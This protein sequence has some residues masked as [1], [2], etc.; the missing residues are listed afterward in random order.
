MRTIG[1]DV[2]KD[3]LDLALW[4]SAET[5]VEHVRCPN[6]ATDVTAAMAWVRARTPDLVVLEATG[7]YHAPMVAALTA[8]DVPLALVNP[9]QLKAERIVQQ[10]RH[11]TDRAD[12]ALLARFAADHA[13]DL[14][15]YVA[16]PAAQA[17]LRAI[18]SYRDGLVARQTELRNQRAAAD[19]HGTTL[20]VAWLDADLVTLAAQLRTVDAEVARALA[21]FPEAAVLVAMP[22][23]GLRVAGGRAGLPAGRGLG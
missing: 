19:W 6:A 7:P 3:T 23:V 18:M 12:A 8:A 15:R 21:A 10:G 1:I 14:R 11:K 2:S 17:H 5:T 22:G 4:D 20:V 16:P 9:A 13:A